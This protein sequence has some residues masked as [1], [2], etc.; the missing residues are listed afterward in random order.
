MDYGGK[1]SHN[2]IWMLLSLKGLWVSEGQTE[3]GYLSFRE[4][5]LLYFFDNWIWQISDISSPAICYSVLYNPPTFCVDCPSV[6]IVIFGTNE[7]S[8]Q[9]T[10][11]KRCCY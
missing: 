3:K 7:G 5:S 1:H 10:E 4:E 6:I 9:T 8:V 2:S 11:W